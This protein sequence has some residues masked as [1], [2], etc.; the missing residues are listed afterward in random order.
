[1]TRIH[2]LLDLPKA[3]RKGDFVQSLAGGIQSP[4]R[5]VDDYA[6]T[7][8][9]VHAY[10]QALSI[11][12]SALT[13]GRSQA[14]TLHGSFGS[15]K[16]HFM[17]ILDLMLADH[18][19][20]W[21]RGEFHELRDAFPWVGD[22]KLLQLPLNMLSA[23]SLEDKIFD[24]Y[25][26]FQE[27][28]HPDAPV[29][30]LYTDQDL[31][32]NARQLRRTMGDESFFAELNRGSKV[33]SGWGDLA[34]ARAWDGERFEA[35]AGG[36][37]D[38]EREKLFS[39]LVK[40]HFPA[41]RREK[42]RFIDVDRG[43]GTLSRHAARL[44]YDAV[45][46]YLDELILW[47][48]SN[49]GSLPFVE[50]EIQKLVK[51]KEAQDEQRDVPIVSFIA[52][53]RDLAQLVG[54][55]ARGDERAALED[56][57]AHN[58]GRFE[59][60]ELA[61]SNLPAIVEHRVVRPRDGDARE[62]LADG[63][64]KTWRGAGNARSTLVGSAG[65]EAAFR[66]VFPFSPALVE[67]LVALSDC[68]Q[69]ERTAIRI[70]MEL[71]VDHLPELELGPV[72]PVGDAF[73]VIAGGEDPFDQVMRARFDRARHLYQESFLPLI[74][75]EHGTESADRC[76]RLRPKHPAR[77]GCSRCPEKACRTDNRLAK[78]LLMAALVPEAP[79]FK[80]LTVKRL[81]HLNHGTIASPIPG[82]EVQSAAQKLRGWQ[83]Q[84]GPLRV[85]E[86][87]DPEISLHLE[88]VDLQPIIDSARGDAVS[89]GALQQR[90]RRI[91]F[92]ELGLPPEV[93]IAQ[94]TVIYLGTRRKGTVRFGNIRK[95]S[96]SQLR[97]P[98]G[99]EWYLVIDY[100][101]DEAGFGPEDDLKAV[102]QIRDTGSETAG[103]PTLYW[104]PTFF[105]HRMER[106][107]EDFVV[108]SEI[109][110]GD[111]RR[112]LGH[113]RP[114]DQIQARG[115]LKNLRAQKRD[116]IVR[117]LK[118]AYGLT[119]PG[120]SPS[121]DPS[122]A[123]EDHVVALD[124]GLTIRALLA[125]T[126]AEG[127]TQLV[128]RVLEHRYPHHPSF[129]ARVTPGKLAEVR[130]LVERLLEEPDHRLPINA[131][132]RKVLRHFGDALGITH[133]SEPAVVLNED[134][135]K[136]LEQQRQQAGL[137]VPTV[138]DV[139][140][141][142]D[143]RGHL[144]LPAEVTDLLVWLYCLWSGRALSRAG[145]AVEPDRQGRLDEDLELFRPELPSET[146]WATALERA[147]ELFGITFAGRHLSARN[148]SKLCARLADAAAEHRMAADI[149]RALERR[150]KQLDRAAG[151]DRLTTAAS[152]A[153]LIAAL[154]GSDGAARVRRL[155]AFPAET[156]LVAVK[157]SLG[158]TSA[159]LAA[160]RSEARWLNFETVR[161]LTAKPGFADRARQIL[162]DLA[163]AL[164]EDE[165]NKP[166][167][168]ELAEL[169]RRAGELIASQR[170]PAD[171]TRVW[172]TR[173]TA[174]VQVDG[175]SGYREKLLELAAA[176]ERE[177][178]ARKPTGELRLELSASVSRRQPDEG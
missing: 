119:A 106:T 152:A 154:Q 174:S 166:L 138:A 34:T 15:G 10:R 54:E 98:E 39:D 84:I 75:A 53:Q 63:F 140:G 170:R 92:A 18:P 90:L 60:V 178:E 37:D 19:A 102:E 8:A 126:L 129:G 57:L 82:A 23:V 150:L 21:R 26:R 118:A 135:F 130:R 81:V 74:Q 95:M 52:K 147:G 169:T 29:P 46:L 115:D 5:T 27:E 144:G 33:D 177:I 68:L 59:P 69:R 41:F 112:Y 67:A 86:Q 168:Q 24:A 40:T 17:A 157:H 87:A 132:E 38:K 108:L 51:L 76:Q 104:L 141:Y 91:L 44:G 3:V 176:L 114:E 122:R 161:G 131:A 107:L 49:A 25:V 20:P 133:T 80:G 88:G 72:V 127:L 12:D 101:F 103:D 165:I 22:K 162:D 99:S 146:E 66:Q 28:H 120:D 61:D 175:G 125:G 96:Q 155:A 148:L 139:R 48:A 7:P 9:I 13:S 173:H 117:A 83:A 35:A 1:M 171:K 121:L 4:D 159:V 158:V 145:R 77:L 47:L 123:V 149:P 116:Q 64:A 71:L 31:F 111:T 62:I 45:V 94:H 151:A 160:L 137:V 6:I 73:D 36:T 79:T 2:D 110:E 50:R 43:L 14:A 156:S 105:S 143:P 11:V 153:G 78:T 93:T 124:P 134:V 164:T 97:C 163:T 42:S 109:L 58:S 55:R 136:Q 85:G 100:P 32:D 142:A 30:A 89:L 16:S 65:N 70:L 56:A 128:H 172:S 113:L 167:A